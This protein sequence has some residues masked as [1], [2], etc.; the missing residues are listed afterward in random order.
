[1]TYQ[2]IKEEN[3]ELKEITVNEEFKEKMINKPFRL[4]SQADIEYLNIQLMFNGLTVDQRSRL[5]PEYI[6]WR[7]K[8]RVASRVR[9]WR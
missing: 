7:H 8:Q 6:E 2:D 3:D 4:M 9:A 5:C 1:M